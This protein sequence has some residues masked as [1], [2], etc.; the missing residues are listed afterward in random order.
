M[1][2]VVMPVFGNSRYLRS[3]ALFSVPTLQ[4]YHT[5]GYDIYIFRQIT[6]YNL[7]NNSYEIVAYLYFNFSLHI[8]YQFTKISLSVI[9]DLKHLLCAA[10]IDNLCVYWRH[11]PTFINLFLSYVLSYS[12][13]F[14]EP[15]NLKL[16][17]NYQHEAL[18]FI[19]KQIDQVKN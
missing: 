3:I 17:L 13:V 14:L 4:R 10:V 1:G 2:V 12:L 5:H 16:Y 8:K 19:L 6:S 18:I 9:F 11:K 15:S 7:I